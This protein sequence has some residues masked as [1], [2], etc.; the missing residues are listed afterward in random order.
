MLEAKNNID[1][2]EGSLSNN[3]N[4]HSPI[5]EENSEVN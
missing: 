3:E 1:A 4:S 5:K 2:M